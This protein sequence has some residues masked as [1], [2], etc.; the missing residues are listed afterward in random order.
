M[1]WGKERSEAWLMSMF[2]SFF[3]SLFVV[4]PIKVFIITGIITCILRKVQ[5]N[6]EEELFVDSGDPIYNAIVSKDE[7]YLHNNTTTTTTS[8]SSIDIKEIL[9][10]RRTKLTAL[11]PIDPEELEKQRQERMR[12]KKT[13]SIIIEG[14]SYFGFLIVVLFLAYQSRANNGYSVKRDLE[15]LFLNDADYAFGDVRQIT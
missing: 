5:D 4:D 14:L 12:Q 10:S 9:E 7:E 8:L 6:E 3:Q 13:N 2:L 15:N 11:R 1:Q